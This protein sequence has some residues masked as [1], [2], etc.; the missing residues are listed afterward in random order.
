GDAHA[1]PG[2]LPKYLVCREIAKTTKVALTGDGGDELFYGYAVFRAERL[3][4][5]VRAIPGAVHRRA[6][7]PLAQLLPASSAY[8]GIDVKAKQFAKGFPA[9]DHL[10]NFYWTSAFPDTELPKLQCDD[11]RDLGDVTIQLERLRARWERASGTFG[12]LA[13]LYQQQYLPDYVLAD[14]DRASMLNSVELRTPFLAP[15]LVRFVNGLP[16]AVKM[17]GGETKSLLRSLG[18]KLLPAG[19]AG[20]PKIGF[21]APVASLI[22]E[23]L[24]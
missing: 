6:V 19:I 9:P 2:L 21:T 16:D 22:S 4:R 18:R 20:R 3:A 10:R 23:E 24:R 5:I 7:Q 1:D 17:R 12:R 14:S 8:L 15:P 13:Y 11:R